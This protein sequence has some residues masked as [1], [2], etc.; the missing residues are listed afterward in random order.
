CLGGIA[1]PTLQSVISNQVSEREQGELQGALTSLV[2]LTAIITPLIMTYIFHEFTKADAR[3]EFAGAPFIGAS[4]FLMFSMYL[5]YRAITKRKDLFKG[6][7]A[8][9]VP[10]QNI[11][12]DQTV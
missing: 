2:S 6:K 12:D 11:V 4:I 8:K 9:E 10:V 1:G 3:V 7:E 5:A